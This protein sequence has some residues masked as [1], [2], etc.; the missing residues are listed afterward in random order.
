MHRSWHTLD[1]PGALIYGK[2]CVCSAEKEPITI[3]NVIQDYVDYA[4]MDQSRMVC[5]N[6]TLAKLLLR[7]FH[8]EANGKRSRR[9]LD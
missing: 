8:G 6:R 3:R 9:I 4:E 2:S 1:D 5:S 7:L